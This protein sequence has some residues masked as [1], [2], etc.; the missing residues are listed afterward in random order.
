[1]EFICFTVLQS[2]QGVFVF[3]YVCLEMKLGPM[4]NKPVCQH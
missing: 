4:Y 2:C 1:M 3:V